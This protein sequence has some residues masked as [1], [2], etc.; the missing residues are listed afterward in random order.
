MI[1]FVVQS[2]EAFKKALNFINSA[3]LLERRFKSRPQE[4]I[5]SV[6]RGC[7]TPSLYRPF[8]AGSVDKYAQRRNPSN[9][10]MQFRQSS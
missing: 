9:R 5:V 8:P 1:F 10:V 2:I 6:V 4:G 7:Y 3:G